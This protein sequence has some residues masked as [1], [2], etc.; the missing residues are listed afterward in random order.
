[1]LKK[2]AG[3]VASAARLN[4]AITET[5]FYEKPKIFGKS[6][7]RH[8]IFDSPG[9]LYCILL[10]SQH[11]RICPFSFMWAGFAR[12]PWPCSLS[13]SCRLSSMAH[14]SSIRMCAVCATLPS[15]AASARWIFS[16]RFSFTLPSHLDFARQS[17]ALAAFAP[18]CL[19]VCLR[20]PSSI[21]KKTI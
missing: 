12:S 5:F 6:N 10:D 18:W 9:A 16:S 14:L 21:K 8:F 3:E 20:S 4:H 2:V 13:A 19:E 7:L 17:S 15:S 1:M 11:Q